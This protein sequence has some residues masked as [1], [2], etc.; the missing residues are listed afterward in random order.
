[1]VQPFGLDCT[2]VIAAYD[3]PATVTNLT[4]PVANG[5]FGVVSNYIIHAYPGW[6][7]ALG[8]NAVAIATLNQNS[9]VCLAAIAPGVL[10]RNSG[11]VVFFSDSTI[12]HAASMNGESVKKQFP[13]S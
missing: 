5:P 1:M 4:H 11:A 8:S 9:Q 12:T 10:S 3:V 13:I 2:G 7:D 6:F